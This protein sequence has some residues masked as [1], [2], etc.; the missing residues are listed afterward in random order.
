[1]PKQ[2]T[3]R[4]L[5]RTSE[6]N[7]EV[8]DSDIESFMSSLHRFLS[9]HFKDLVR[10][11]KG[12]PESAVISRLGGLLD[13]L[14]QAGLDDEL[15]K[16]RDLY[17]KETK[18]VLNSFKDT[19]PSVSIKSVTD[20]DTVEAFISMREGDVRAQV[21]SVASQVSSNILEQTLIGEAVVAGD[22]TKTISAGLDKNFK[23]ELR[24][25]LM[26][27]HRTVS[28]VHASELG[29]K[30]GYYAG[31]ILDNTREF[32]RS[33]LEDRDPPIYTLDEIEAMDNEQGLDVITSG[34]GYNCVHHWR[35]ISQRTARDL[36]WEPE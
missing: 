11:L 17:K 8:L 4:L 24:T 28:K 2:P 14:K 35:W 33:L 36:G 26:K 29:L 10:E 23:T 5:N 13:G 27:F 6:S 30:L 34:G 25:G 32:C 7:V 15:A 31:P 21:E 19:E 20:R 16:I 9:N 12:K 22:V 1:M 3:T 18:K